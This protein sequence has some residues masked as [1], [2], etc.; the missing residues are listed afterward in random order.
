MFRNPFY[1]G[2]MLSNGEMFEGK[3][4]PIVSKRLFD[5]VQA[6]MERKSKAKTPQLKPYLYRG[7]F[8]CGECGC[9]ITTETQ[10]GHNYLRC[11]KR[12][13]ACSQK[14]VREEVITEQADRVISRVTLEA[15]LADHMV[16]ALEKERD[17]A[18]Q[19]A[20]AAVEATK[21]AIATTEKQ[22]DLI[23]DMRLAEQ[24]GDTEYVIK[25]SA[26]MNRKAE[27]KGKLEQFE[28]NRR[29]RF[30]PAIRF[31]LEAK[32]GAKLLADGKP[33]EKRDFLKKIGSNLRLAEKALSVEFK[34]P[35][36]FV[37]DFNSKH[38]PVF[39]DNEFSHELLNWR[40]GRDFRAK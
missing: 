23:L 21:A 10:K 32:H 14:Y 29:N 5:E 7:L 9:S 34:T 26:L 39:A 11:T 30:E 16:M 33:E 19:E 22:I 40:R 15:S 28:A 17:T 8:Q 20:A 36:Q 27:L 31:V 25:K 12:V 18:V 3:H 38:A 13:T 24:I 2:V 6:V 1:Y 35:W 37:A 4:E